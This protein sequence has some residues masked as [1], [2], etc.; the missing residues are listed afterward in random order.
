MGACLVKGVDEKAAFS[1]PASR[2]VHKCI[3][4]RSR[5]ARR[6]FVLEVRPQTG[7][8]NQIRVQRRSAGSRVSRSSG[9]RSCCTPS[10]M[11]KHAQPKPRTIRARRRSPSPGARASAG[12]EQQQEHQRELSN[13]ELLER[14]SRELELERSK[15][16][17]GAAQPPDARTPLLFPK[18]PAT[19]LGQGWRRARARRHKPEGFETLMCGR[20]GN[21][22]ARGFDAPAESGR[23]TCACDTGCRRGGTG[24]RV[25]DRDARVRCIASSTCAEPA[26]V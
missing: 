12:Q 15:G 6:G 4:W 24:A 10:V 9:P 5:G 25:I 13:Y 16:G 7:K 23:L 19:N 11:A 18:E 2:S 3:R 20:R 8:R 22:R 21:P 1:L 14:R 26:R 17:S